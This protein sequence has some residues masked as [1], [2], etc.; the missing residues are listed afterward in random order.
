M[1][2]VVYPCREFFYHRAISLLE[3]R[4][5]KI[6]CNENN[7]F[8]L[9]KELDTPKAKKLLDQAISKGLISKLKA[10]YQWSNNIDNPLQL[11]AY[12]IEKANDYLGLRK[13]NKRTV[14]KPFKQLF[15]IDTDDRKLEVAKNDYTKIYTNFTPNGCDEIDEFFSGLNAN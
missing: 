8:I 13:S 10:C 6:N 9:P 5:N 11:Q 4:T 7:A 14:W 1:R 3:S 12:F 2:E 15:G